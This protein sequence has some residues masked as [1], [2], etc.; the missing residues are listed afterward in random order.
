MLKERPSKKVF[1]ELEGLDL[2]RRLELLKSFICSNL[3]HQ[4][5]DHPVDVFDEVGRFVIEDYPRA[6]YLVGQMVSSVKW[7]AS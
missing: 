5:V 1:A 6:N 4:Q 2:P 7:D 3:K